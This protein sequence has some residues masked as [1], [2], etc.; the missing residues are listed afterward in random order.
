MQLGKRKPCA[1]F[2]MMRLAGECYMSKPKMIIDTD[3]HPVPIHEQVA[4]YLEEPW[5]ARYL[6]GDHGAGH[7]VGVAVSVYFVSDKA[8]LHLPFF[9]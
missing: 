8:L 5:R 7:I 9:S 4:E 6:R 2:Q 3:L 1:I